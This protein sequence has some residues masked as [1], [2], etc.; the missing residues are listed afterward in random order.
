MPTIELAAPINRAIFPGYAK[1]ASDKAAFRST[2]VS[3]IGL[4]AL[5][6]F[7]AGIG[8]AAIADPLV[9]VALGEQWLGAIPVVALL[10]VYGAIAALGT[11]SGY[12]FIALGQP[13][14][15]TWLSGVRAVALLPILIVACHWNGAVGAAWG[16]LLLELVYRPLTFAVVMRS[17]EMRAAPLV[18]CLWR[19]IVAAV[20]MYFAVRW[21]ESA[22]SSG[23]SL[24]DH[25]YVLAVGVASGVVVYA[26]C[27][28]LLWIGSGAPAGAERMAIGGAAALLRK[29]IA[30]H[31]PP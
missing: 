22:V 8:I 13:Q 15:L 26:I 29:Q 27:V 7:P 10:G 1:L 9:H 19:P 12:V 4:M 3:T 23:G 6:A 2:F 21:V 16:V 24:L 5:V 20:P 18:A 28:W 11:N 25:A 31:A 17:L 14:I 30:V